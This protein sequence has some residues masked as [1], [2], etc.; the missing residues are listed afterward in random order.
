[1]NAPNWPQESGSA[2]RR[3]ELILSQLEGRC[4]LRYR[5]ISIPPALAQE[6][7]ATG[8]SPQYGHPVQTEVAKGYG[9]CRQCLR[10]FHQGEERRLLFTY[11]PF[12]KLTDYPSPGPIFIHEAE[13]PSFDAV[14]AFPPELRDL[15]LMFEAYERDR[16]LLLHEPVVASEI[17]STISRLLGLPS[18]EYLHVRNREAGCYIAR[19]ERVTENDAPTA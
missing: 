13:C 14:C 8:K 10:K 17:E 1:M 2:K 18:V 15:P 7:R 16:W 19:V 4:L 11:N 3:H 9:P 6:V 5:V 12:E